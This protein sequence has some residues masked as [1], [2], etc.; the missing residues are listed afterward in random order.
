MGSSGET[1]AFLL[2]FLCFKV[3]YMS[4]M[5]FICEPQRICIWLVWALSSIDGVGPLDEDELLNLP[6][7]Q[8]AEE[9]FGVWFDGY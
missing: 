5:G 3:T 7:C 8:F 2:D 9:L 4:V 1:T 6:W